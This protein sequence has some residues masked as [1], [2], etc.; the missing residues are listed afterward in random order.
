MIYEH[1]VTGKFISRPNRFIAHV[2]IN[3]QTAVCHVKNTGRCRELLLPGV[4]VILEYHPGALA[5]GRKTEYDLIGV[6]KEKLLINMDSQ[7]PNKAA[8]E[9]LDGM[10]AGG[11]LDAAL[12]PW[13]G[14][15][16]TA[17]LTARDGRKMAANLTT[18]DRRKMAAGP[19]A[20]NCSR[21]IPARTRWTG[22]LRLDN[23]RRE[24]THGDSRFDLAF[25]LK[26]MDGRERPAFMEVK[27]VTLE[28]NGIAMFPDAP[29]ERGIKHLNG[30]INA[31]SQG[32][33]AYVL[34][35]IQMKKIRAFR[36]NDATHPAFG[37]TLRA[38]AHAGVHVLAYDCLIS[39]DSMIIDAPVPVIL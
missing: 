10:A 34:L 1:I 29:T 23:L 3:G 21:D 31:V 35:V 20:Q 14:E 15:E 38:A 18:Q 4:T 11:E 16:M 22:S 8:W 6:Y 9:W 25:T 30:L 13:D 27:G 19:T 33:E 17:D 7:A 5:A 32:Y 37:E 24:V 28:E 36:P 39:P 26:S 12:T 2:D